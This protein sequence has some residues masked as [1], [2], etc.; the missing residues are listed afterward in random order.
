ML[1]SLYGHEE[2][3]GHG[4]ERGYRS[5][6]TRS[7]S[8]SSEISR[9]RI[10]NHPPPPPLMHRQSLDYTQTPPPQYSNRDQDQDQGSTTTQPYSSRLYS[11][12]CPSSIGQLTYTE[13]IHGISKCLDALYFLIQTAQDLT[14]L[15]L[16]QIKNERLDQLRLNP[17]S[18]PLSDLQHEIGNTINSVISK[19][20]TYDHGHVRR[21]VRN[22]SVMLAQLEELS[23]WTSELRERPFWRVEEGCEGLR[24]IRDWKSVKAKGVM[25][26]IWDWM[27]L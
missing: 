25:G 21:L 12:S 6:V 26:A 2:G 15:P 7:V 17:N 8:T 20:V 24:R 19:L 9:Y 3:I 1:D 14:D 5:S 11:Y 10:R 22:R 18:I 23:G 13:T 27:V 16:V 4:H